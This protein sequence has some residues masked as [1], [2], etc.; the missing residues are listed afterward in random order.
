MFIVS[1][2][3]NAEFYLSHLQPFYMW[4]LLKYILKK[5]IGMWNSKEGFLDEKKYFKSVHPTTKWNGFYE[6]NHYKLALHPISLAKNLRK[7]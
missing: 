1:F 6:N 3:S 2:S 4:T 5:E 7:T